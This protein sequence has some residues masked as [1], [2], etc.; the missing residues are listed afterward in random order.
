VGNIDNC[1]LSKQV[2]EKSK[3]DYIDIWVYAKTPLRLLLLPLLHQGQMIYCILHHQIIL[4]AGWVVRTSIQSYCK[5]SWRVYRNFGIIPTKPETG[6]GYIERK[7]DDVVSFREKPNQVMA[8]E[9]IAR[10]FSM[11][12][13]CSALKHWC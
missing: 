5:S 6:Y 7:G 13:V 1:H 2:L 11:E 12:A 4:L 3:T 8:R 9:F 10:G